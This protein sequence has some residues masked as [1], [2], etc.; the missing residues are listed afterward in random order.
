[1]P[2]SGVMSRSAKPALKVVF[3]GESA[4]GF[5]AS[6]A[7]RLRATERD[8]RSGAKRGNGFMLKE[9]AESQGEFE[10]CYAVQARRRIATLF[11]RAKFTRGGGTR[12]RAQAGGS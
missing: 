5:F 6:A 10:E 4:A 9:T 3:G 11:A 12:P 1:M 2:M 7:E 8:K